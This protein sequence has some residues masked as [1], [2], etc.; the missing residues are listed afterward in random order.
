MNWIGAADSPR[1]YIF[2]ADAMA[3]AAQLGT[4]DAAFGQDWVLP[5]S[6]PLT[7]TQVAAI[8]GRHL[9]RP[10][11]LRAAGTMTLRLV[12]LLNRELRGFMQVVPDYVKPI[13]YDA[14]KLAGLIG[15]P[16]LTSYDIGIAR[17]LDAIAAAAA[18]R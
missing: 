13:A 14:A 7:G 8:A 3:I 10:V 15:S 1:E 16:Q 5:G 18:P 4:L 2:V 17:T 12:S 11:K 6:G 9:G